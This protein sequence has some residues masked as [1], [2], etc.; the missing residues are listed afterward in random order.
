M[1]FLRQKSCMIKSI[2]RISRIISYY[3]FL[4]LSKLEFWIFFFIEFPGRVKS[5]KKFIRWKKRQKILQ[6][7]Y[8]DRAVILGLE[9]YNQ[10]YTV[11]RR[12]I[13]YHPITG[14]CFKGVV[15][16][17]ISVTINP[18]ANRI[19]TA[20]S[21]LVRHPEYREKSRKSISLDTGIVIYDLWSRGGYA[22]FL[23]ELIGPIL[24][25]TDLLLINKTVP[26]LI[27]SITGYQKQILD[28]L[29]LNYLEISD[30]STCIIKKAYIPYRYTS[31]TNLN[32]RL[33]QLFKIDKYTNLREDKKICFW[34]EST[35]SRVFDNPASAREFFV[36]NGFL[37]IEP[38]TLSV[39]DQAI[40][41]YGADII[42]GVHGSAF[43]NL[44]FTNNTRFN[45][46]R[47]IEIF[48]YRVPLTFRRLALSL[49]CNY[50]MV[51]SDFNS[52]DNIVFNDELM[53]KLKEEV[54]H[55]KH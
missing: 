29:S 51:L 27:P 33:L 35:N 43:A 41:V 37:V 21:Y 25:D 49:D 52:D 17:G 48:G 30:T 4:L 34:R 20:L 39:R 9:F 18:L 54:Q 22:H 8:P 11:K 46:L 19:N 12:N 16:I 40:L 1:I 2:V 38:E 10:P 47:V 53:N 31:Y 24:S 32:F 15:P 42:I 13:E 55:G 50:S 5:I 36:N 14:L 6:R 28:D 26:L 23:L 45:K 3:F 7:S 44:I